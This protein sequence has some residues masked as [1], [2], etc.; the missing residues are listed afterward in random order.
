MTE[1]TSH[2]SQTFLLTCVLCDGRLLAPREAP[3]V[4]SPADA[5]LCSCAR[6]G[7]Y[8]ITGGFA[9][10]LAFDPTMRRA[11]SAFVRDSAARGLVPTLRV[12]HQAA[13]EIANPFARALQKC[14]ACRTETPK[15]NRFRAFVHRGELETACLAAEEWEKLFEHE[16]Q[17][18]G[19]S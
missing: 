12:Q 2:G 9:H 16:A 5:A 8:R 1:A 4:V 11:A 13:R 14:P 17:G 7:L 15:R 6:C 19:H 10:A 3:L 18:R